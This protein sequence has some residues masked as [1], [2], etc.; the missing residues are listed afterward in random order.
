M[1]HEQPLVDRKKLVQKLQNG[2]CVAMV[3]TKPSFWPRHR[4]TGADVA[5]DELA[6]MEAIHSL[7]SHTYKRFIQSHSCPSHGPADM[8]VHNEVP[9]DLVFVPTGRGHGGAE[10]GQERVAEEGGRPAPVSLGPTSDST[11]ALPE[12]T[13]RPA[14]A[15]RKALEHTGCNETGDGATAHASGFNSFEPAARSGSCTNELSS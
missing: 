9:D 13:A 7:L 2:L 10:D 6:R 5:L 1:P 8:E 3:G 11:T 12:P 4:W 14:L 15:R